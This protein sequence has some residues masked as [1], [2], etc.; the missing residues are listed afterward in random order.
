MWNERENEWT[1]PFLVSLLHW[2]LSLLA[3]CSLHQHPV[4]DM[5]VGLRLC[6]TTDFSNYCPRDVLIF[7]LFLLTNMNGLCFN[8]KLQSGDKIEI[9]IPAAP[10]S[11]TGTLSTYINPKL[12][13][14]RRGCFNITKAVLMKEESD[15]L[16]RRQIISHGFS[17]PLQE[18]EHTLNS[19]VLF[20]LCI[21]FIVESQPFDLLNIWEFLSQG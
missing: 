8:L 4:F 18:P 21:D 7:T 14:I 3:N 15:V 20:H 1:V 12:T 9:A 6:S 5:D 11:V 2:T 13:Q 17:L 16:M 10:E 19:D